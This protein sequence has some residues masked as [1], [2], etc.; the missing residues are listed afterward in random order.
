MKFT[1]TDFVNN[2]SDHPD[3]LEALKMCQN[4]SIRGAIEKF[5]SLFEGILA[6][7]EVNNAAEYLFKVMLEVV[8]IALNIEKL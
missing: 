8:V 5:Y 3:L 7:E 1:Y 4:V 6:V 2:L